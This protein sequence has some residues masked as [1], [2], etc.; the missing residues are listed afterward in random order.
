MHGPSEERK[1][2][3]Q[4]PYRIAV[5]PGDGIGKEVVPEGIRV[6]EA[7]GARFGIAF[8]W[9][10]LTWSCEYYT[11][12]GRMMPEDGLEQI[13]HQDAIFLG[14][15]GF[16]GVPDHVSLW[17]LLLPI[18][19]GFQQYANIRPV[20]L[21]PGIA[22]PLRGREPGDIDF[23][24]VRENPELAAH[25]LSEAGRHAEAVGHWLAAGRRASHRFANLEAAANLTRGLE[26]LAMLEPTPQ[27]LR[28][29]LAPQS[30]LGLATIMAQ[31][32]AAPEVARAFGRAH[33]ICTQLG[34]TA[35]TAP[36]LFGLWEYYL[37]RGE[38]R[39]A[40]AIA[41]KLQ[42]LLDTGEVAPHLVPEMERI[43]GITQMWCGQT[44]PALARLALAFAA[45]SPP[46]P[47]H[48]SGEA[49]A[50]AVASLS[51]VAY[52]AVAS[53]SQA[54]CALWLSAQPEAALAAAEEALDIARSL[55][56]PFSHA[57][58][59]GFLSILHQLRGNRRAALPYARETREIATRYEF[60]FWRAF[61]AML[62][63]WALDSASPEH[64]IDAF[65]TGIEAYR[66]TGARLALTH[67]LSL[68]AGLYR[69]AGRHADAEGLYAEALA[70]A[71]QT[72]TR[73]IGLRAA[74]ALAR[75]LAGQGRPG[76]ARSLLEPWLFDM[77][78]ARSLPEWLEAQTTLGALTE[79]SAA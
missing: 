74:T 59:S 30:S 5:I 76:E 53:R 52:T 65:E 78:G 62:E 12:T 35:A 54:A 47:R 3:N 49:Q 64:W 45:Q 72:G 57:Y 13:R 15:V 9:D 14:A 40:S 22:S 71:A 26:A 36:V 31:G 24:V 44:E 63:A 69:E 21:M 1:A 50:G 55:E 33:E 43:L 8:E 6:L 48:E 11:R 66:E 68:L 25:H 23:I 10:E 32:Y 4:T 60:A 37:V 70:L 56:H 58:A 17:G 73:L 7:A 28:M 20:R 16:P 2:L 19:R 34:L 61:A 38:L 39:E 41:A 79:G 46:A 29:E 18:R 51:Q 42:A 77:D 75:H 67:L 27:T